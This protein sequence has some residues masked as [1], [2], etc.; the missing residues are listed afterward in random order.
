MPANVRAL[1]Y[2]RQSKHRAESITHELQEQ[3]CRAYAQQRGYEVVEVFNEK[4]KSGTSVV[5]RVEFKTALEMMSEGKA[6]VMLVWRWS[7]FARNTLDGLMTLKMV[8][9]EAGGRVECS[10]ETIDRSALGKFSLTL[11]LG[12]AELESNQKSDLW[13]D[14]NDFRLNEGLPPG[15]RDYWGYRKVGDVT[16]N[17]HVSHTG[18]EQVP[19]TATLVRESMQRIIDG[20]S[21]RSTA[22]WLNSQGERT[23]RGAYFQGP[24][25]RSRLMNPF[26]RGMI[27][28]KGEE[29]PGK[30]EAIISE[31]M[32][33][34][35][36]KV[37]EGNKGTVRTAEPVS[38]LVGLV[39]CEQCGRLLSYRKNLPT[40]ERPNRRPRMVCSSRQNMGPGV[41]DLPSIEADEINNALDWWLPRHA[42]DIEK[43]VPN[44]TDIIEQIE[45]LKAKGD[46]VQAR[47]TQTLTVG[48]DAG[49]S[50]TQMTD[51]LTK[52]REE[53]EAIQ[54]EI[55]SLEAEATLNVR[56]WWDI[57]DAIQGDDTRASNGMLKK[58]L[59]KIVATKETLTFIPKVGPSWV[60]YLGSGPVKEMN[61]LNQK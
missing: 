9:E 13:K 1:I 51:A 20:H 45:T 33:R 46:A 34:Q 17:G 49:L 19:E 15:G 10:T 31:G 16:K 7:R 38:R 11:M 57:E 36:R 14:A 32:F 39:E 23:Q 37:L 55:D 47:V 50:V 42:K 27:N 6:Q 35:F 30:H 52:L 41:C 25:L 60:W 26:I 21:L 59:N 58:V 53:S 18:Y 54:Q 3:S 12:M 29:I 61:F 24:S 43:S 44:Q 8:E 40:T 56:P 4:G 28:W 5:K 22:M 2:T 48:S